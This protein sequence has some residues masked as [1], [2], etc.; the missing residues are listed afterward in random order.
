M[1]NDEAKFILRARRPGGPDARDAAFAEA[2][3]H[4]RRDPELATW[5]AE[6]SA[7]DAALFAQLSAVPVPSDLKHAIL[8]GRKVIKPQPWW[9][10]PVSLPTAV[11]AVVATL[12][13]IAFVGLREPREAALDFSRF[14]AD[15]TDYVGSRY[16]LLFSP[17]LATA[18]MGYLGAGGSELHYRSARVEDI[19]RWL[20]ENSGHGA[21]EFPA[22]LKDHPSMG[23]GMLDWRGKRVSLV[24]FQVGTDLPKDKVYLV[25]IDSADLPDPPKGASP[26]FTTR[27]E[28]TSATWRNGDFVCLLLGYGNGETLA[29]YF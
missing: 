19:R 15:L 25:V 23:C 3:A 13:C 4:A 6:E 9:R 10:Q 7:I 5:F 12:L 18:N 14:N 17:K 21:C 27:G 20:T 24:C 22:R 11:A 29:R 2:L 1:N 28:W 8:I 26:Q 16:G